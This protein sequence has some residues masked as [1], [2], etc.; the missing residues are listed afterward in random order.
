MEGAFKEDRG[1]IYAQLRDS[2]TFA[3][4]YVSIGEL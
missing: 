1:A 2:R 3:Y 4:D